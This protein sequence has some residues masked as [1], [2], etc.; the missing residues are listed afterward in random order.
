MKNLLLICIVTLFIACKGEKGDV[1][2]AGPQGEKG[3]TGAVGT[4]GPAGPQG[5]VGATGPAGPQGVPGSTVQ[6]SVYDFTLDV[7]KALASYS[8][9]KQLGSYDIVLVYLKK[10]ESFYTQLPFSGYSYTSDLKD[11]LKVDLNFDYST[12]TL[13]I[14]KEG[15]LPTGATFLFRAVVL[16]GAKGGRLDLERYRDYNNLKADF[17]LKD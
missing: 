11:F 9:P 13:Y 4:T 8:W 6:P 1:G 16:K 2:P 10:S 5:P 12:L 15:N 14:N 3:A 17:G 7:S